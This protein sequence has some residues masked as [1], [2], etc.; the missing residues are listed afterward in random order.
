MLGLHQLSFQGANALLRVGFRLR[1]LGRWPTSADQRG[2]RATHMLRAVPIE[3]LIE[4][5]R[6]QPRHAVDQGHMAIDLASRQ[7]FLD[8][9]D[10]RGAI[11]VLVRHLNQPIHLQLPHHG[12][13]SPRLPAIVRQ[14]VHRGDLRFCGQLQ[15]VFMAQRAI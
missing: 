2:L 8:R 13:A 11:E 4:Q 9:G 10:V 14:L 3:G 15:Q 7:E 12:S 5:P 1:P 6:L